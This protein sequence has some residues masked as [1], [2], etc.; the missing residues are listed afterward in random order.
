MWWDRADAYT[1]EGARSAAA[2]L[3]TKLRF[4]TAMP[5]DCSAK[6]RGL[7]DCPSLHHALASGTLTFDQADHL[8]HVFTEERATYVERDADM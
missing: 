6:A 8:I 5:S 2:W 3:R 7:R 4:L 1:V